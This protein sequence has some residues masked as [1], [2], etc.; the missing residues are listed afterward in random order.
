MNAF[1]QWKA[2]KV[3][4]FHDIKVPM[5]DCL[6]FKGDIY[7]PLKDEKADVQPRPVLLMVSPYLTTSGLANGAWPIGIIP[8]AVDK[9]FNVAV[10]STRGTY[11]NPGAQN[12]DTEG[13]D[14]LDA[15]KWVARQPWCG[16]KI[17]TCGISYLGLTQTLLNLK[18]GVPELETSVINSPA[19]G[20]GLHMLPFE[21]C[22]FRLDDMVQWNIVM[23]L[24]R[25]LNGSFDE[26]TQ[27]QIS[28]DNVLVDDIYSHF[29]RV[30]TASWARKYGLRN[31]PI[32][33][34]MPVYRNWVENYD[35]KAAFGEPKGPYH[36][37]NP[38]LFVSG[39]ND[40]FAINTLELYESGNVSGAENRHRLV[41][42]PWAH[43][44][45]PTAERFIT[46][47]TNQNAMD[48]EW[49]CD[50]AFGQ[51]SEF[52]EKTPVA[53]Y[54]FGE[55][56]WRREKQWPLSD[57]VYT[58]YY[59]HSDGSANS[60]EGDGV[61]STELPKQEKTDKYI[62]D[63]A[64]PVP[65]LLEHLMNGGTCD[66]SS[67]EKREDVLCYTSPVLEE[68]VD[69]TG[70]IKGRIFAASS[71]DDTDF[72]MKLV[73]VDEN[74]KAINLAVGGMRG[75]YR[76]DRWN[77][78]PIVPGEIYEYSFSMRAV[79]C[80]IKKNHRIR[81]EVVSTDVPMYDPN[82]NRFI[83]L[84]EVTENDY[85]TAE[86]TVYHDAEHASFIELPIIPK[87]HNT[88][89]IEWPFDIATAGGMDALEAQALT[90][91]IITSVDFN[92]AI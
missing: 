59:L 58:K 47:L 41:M 28:E 25:M 78:E 74:G 7:F 60:L 65:T 48:L 14:A 80:I 17:L 45:V 49:L 70:Y 2:Y 21:N 32:A 31:I 1:E 39:W 69:I 6:E 5:S 91:L 4:R 63:P 75:R 46:G 68:D 56:R 33:R 34:R 8:D 27:K 44:V 88:D 76:K 18:G 83:D 3:A 62:S 30:D 66:Q 10:I 84:R 40:I 79:S 42:G 82:P 43:M 38:C 36:F 52:F 73:D 26:E 90:E 11:G 85:V 77:P 29:E 53:L 13:E 51:K 15:A 24:D 50:K 9:G 87:S 71:A 19:I 35:N 20:Q 22:F 64:N 92:E 57:T 72:I 12:P 54:S 61:L 16:D 23:S 37:E 67:N 55:N 86:Q 89:W 81:V